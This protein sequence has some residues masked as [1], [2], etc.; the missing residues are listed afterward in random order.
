[1]A[2]G[3][4]RVAV[5]IVGSAAAAAGGAG[6][7]TA[8]LAES[9]PARRL[10]VG[11]AALELAASQIMQRSMGITANRCGPGPRVVCNSAATALT[12]A[13]RAPP[14]RWELALRR[15]RRGDGTV[16]LA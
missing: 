3:Q 13:A 11:G 9:G 8:P 6:L 14:L 12:R 7:L 15:S 16:G 10:A 1:M 4:A 5:R 2:R